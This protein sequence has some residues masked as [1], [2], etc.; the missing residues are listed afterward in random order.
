MERF[1]VR[2]RIRLPLS[3]YS[4]RNAFFITLTTHSKYPW[5]ALHPRLCDMPIQILVELQSV[6]GSTIYAWCIMPDH[7]HLLLQDTQLV[8]FVRIFKGRMTPK[9]RK[10]KPAKRLWQRSFFDH[11]LRKEESLVDVACYIWENPVRATLV[12]SPKEYQWSGSQ[13]WLEWREF[14]GR[15]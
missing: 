14:Y 4:Q 15:G 12:E 13:V 6:R 9:A 5:F 8:D 2:K 1:P 3:V 7:I 10:I 11:A